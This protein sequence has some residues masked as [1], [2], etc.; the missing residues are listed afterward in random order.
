[1]E[2]ASV[3]MKKQNGNGIINSEYLRRTLAGYLGKPGIAPPNVITVSGLNEE[4]FRKIHAGFRADVYEFGCKTAVA[5][6]GSPFGERER[7]YVVKVY[8]RGEEI[9]D[10]LGM[11]Q[12]V[13]VAEREAEVLRI[14]SASATKY[15]PRFIGRTSEDGHLKVAMEHLGTESFP[16]KPRH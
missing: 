12:G 6:G 7:K 1:M 14:L 15:L 5:S 11:P 8:R 3:V 10:S 16:L 2:S 4:T 9:R 13:V